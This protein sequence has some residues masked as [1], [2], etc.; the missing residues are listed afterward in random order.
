MTYTE[1]T[2][3]IPREKRVTAAPACVATLDRAVG[4]E[5]DHKRGSVL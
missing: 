4:A 3:T 2:N 5:S 1:Y